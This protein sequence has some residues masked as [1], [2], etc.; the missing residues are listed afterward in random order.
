MKKFNLINASTIDGAVSS[1]KEH[2][3]TAKIIAGGTDLLCVMKDNINPVYPEVLVNVESIPDLDYIRE[4]AGLLKIGALA[5]VED[6]AEDTTVKGK[7]VSLAQ[8]AHAVGTPLLRNMGTIAGN[9]CQETRCWYYRAHNNRFYC[10]RKGGTL[11][12][13]MAGD[14]RYNAILGGQVC[15]AVCPSDTAI[16]LTALGATIITTERSIAIEDFYKTLGNV[17]GANE[18]ITEIQVP[19]PIS[20]TKQTF[21]KYSLRKAIDF[22]IS[23]VAAS[24]TLDGGVVADARIVMGGVAPVP[25]R[26]TDAEDALKGVA[27]SES[28]AEAAGVAAT[29]DALPLAKNAYIIQIT[30]TLVKRAILSLK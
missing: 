5:L 14:N 23:S 17:L 2:G 7:Y 22:A 12:N 27:V 18:I 28:S 24:I 29:K 13:A 8:A 1:L 19:E 20:G 3:G 25:Y 9:L 15:F 26:A 6:I 4:E 10:F 16:A 11:C 30:K 21:I